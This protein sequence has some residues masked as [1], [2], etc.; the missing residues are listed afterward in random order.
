MT[1]LNR[2]EYIVGIDLGAGTSEASI[3]HVNDPLNIISVSAWDDSMRPSETFFSSILYSKDGSDAPIYGMQ[4]DD[5]GDIGVYVNNI[6]QYIVD[7][8]ASDEKLGQLMDGLTVR[9]VVTDYLRY[10]VVFALKRLQVH[11]KLVKNEHFQEFVNEEFIDEDIKTIGYC[12]VCPADRQEYMKDCFIEAGII[13]EFEAEYR[14][15]FVI[16]AVA[17]AHSQLSRDRNETGI[18]ENQD[19]FVLDVGDISIGVA[20]IHAASTISLSTITEISDDATFGLKNLD[21]KFKEYLIKNM[22]ELNL[23]I[24]LINRFVRTFSEFIEYGFHMYIP[25]GTAMSQDDIDGNPIEF[26]YE[27]LDRIVFKPF[28]ESIAASIIKADKSYV[29][30]KKFSTEKYG[31]NEYFIKNLLARDE[32]GLKYHRSIIGCP[33]GM[34]SWG[35]V[36]SILNTYKSQTPFSLYNEHRSS[37]SDRGLSLPEIVSKESTD[38]NDGNDAYDFTL[39]LSIGPI[40]FWT[41]TVGIDALFHKLPIPSVLLKKFTD[42]DF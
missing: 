1:S 24:S 19:Y 2:I 41:D 14:L 5:A 31:I 26:T 6:R 28:I 33:L 39:K 13:E 18:Q 22:T 17:I 7:V 32:G 34:V 4:R 42:T 38:D 25:T 23:N 30:C 8:D 40:A 36:S 21:N 16:E 35:A 37:F 12:L 11:K 27:D 9:K 10:F 29:Q 3:A 20:K 15:S